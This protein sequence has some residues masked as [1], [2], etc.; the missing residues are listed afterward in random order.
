M[1]TQP[2]KNQD[3]PI[4]DKT[5]IEKLKRILESAH[6]A[7]I[8]WR[9]DLSRDQSQYENYRDWCFCQVW[10]LFWDVASKIKIDVDYCDPDT[11]CEADMQARLDSYK[12]I[13]WVIDLKE[14]L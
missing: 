10:D 7:A 3:S 4:S 6:D 12:N 11:T 8:V 9:K 5:L 2:L 14:N 1:T 13:D